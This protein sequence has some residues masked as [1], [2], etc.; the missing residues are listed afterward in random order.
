MAL[1]RREAPEQQQIAARD[2]FQW[3]RDML[4][5]DPFKEMA[6]A[7]WMGP[8]WE[9]TFAPAFEVKE[10]ADS[11]QFKA[12]LPGVKEPD[13]E[14]KLAGNRLSISGKRESEKQDKNDTY[15]TYER[16]YGSFVRSFALPDGADT[17]HAIAELKDG[18]L[19]IAIPKKPGNGSKTIAVKTSETKKS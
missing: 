5:W 1:I 6:P 16:S 19:T 12:D 8:S 10:T 7:S 18:V 11:F 3:M 13:L 17:D 15:Y 14:V 9:P 4:R 2:P